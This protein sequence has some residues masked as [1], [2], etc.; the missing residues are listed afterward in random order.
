MEGEF[1]PKFTLTKVGT[2]KKS[3]SYINGE[4]FDYIFDHLEKCM[5]DTGRKISTGDIAVSPINGRE[6]PACKYCEYGHICGIEDSFIPTVEKMSNEDV[7][8]TIKGDN[9]AD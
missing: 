1:V 2:P 8:N 4:D 5:S 6:S 7:I 3:S 9:N